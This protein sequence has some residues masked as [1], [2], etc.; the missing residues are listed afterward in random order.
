MLGDIKVYSFPMWMVYAP[1]GYLI[2]GEE[3]EEIMKIIKPG[4]I[5]LRG[6]NDYLDGK[7]IKGYYKQST[8]QAA[9]FSHAGFY[10]KEKNFQYII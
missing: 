4:D 1:Q 5:L 10:Y 8:H 3:T 2:K 7:V 6:Y 9:S